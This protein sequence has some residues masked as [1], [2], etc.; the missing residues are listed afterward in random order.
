MHKGIIVLVAF[1]LHIYGFAQTGKVILQ[2]E[3]VQTKKGGEVIT[4][5]FGSKNF[6]KTGKELWTT[7]KEVSSAKMVFIFENLSPGE[8][9][10]VAYQDIDRNK[11]MKT[12]FIGYPKEPWGISNNPRILFGPP[13]FNESKVKVNA[14]QTTTVNIRLN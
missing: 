2:I 3:N 10:F 7:S 4:A 8:Y 14:N 12:N 1:F 13:S 9:A 11:R 5:A 6:L